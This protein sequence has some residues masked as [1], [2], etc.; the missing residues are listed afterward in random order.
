[1][2]HALTAVC[3]SL[4]IALAVMEGRLDAASAFAAAQLDKTFQIEA[5]RRA[6]AADIA[7]AARFIELL[8][9]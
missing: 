5:R 2:L 3:G 1:M 4:V 8:A 6:L 9:S 7:A